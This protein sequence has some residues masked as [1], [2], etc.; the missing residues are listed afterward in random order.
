MKKQRMMKHALLLLAVTSFAVVSMSAQ[1]AIGTVVTLSGYVLNANSLTPVDAS[2]ALYD[3]AGKKMGQSFRANAKDGYLVTG[4]QPGQKYTI[5][6]EDPRFFKQEFVIDIPNTKKYAEI[7]KDFVVRPLEAGKSVAV[8]PTPFDLK[9]TTLKVGTEDEIADVA[10][11]LVMNPGVTVEL[12]CYPDEDGTAESAASMSM[13]RGN[14]LKAALV[15][16]GVPDGRVSVR[17]V[18]GT[19]PINPPPLRK[20]AK[21]KRYVGPTYLFITKV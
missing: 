3:A 21:G 2:Y 20:G 18:R 5:K 12:V 11:L 8:T 6:V 9:K 7:S 4:L 15:K 14:A 10:R 1:S 17:T 19:D 16:A 13:A